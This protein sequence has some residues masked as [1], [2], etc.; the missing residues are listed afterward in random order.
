M[1]HTFG[2]Q[3]AQHGGHVN[4]PNYT[5]DNFLLRQSID[6]TLVDGAVVIFA[7]SNYPHCS[8]DLLTALVMSN[9][10]VH[11]ENQTSVARANGISKGGGKNANN[12]T[13]KRYDE[14]ICHAI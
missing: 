6:I 2:G 13:L 11:T 7:Q 3:H 12:R 5:N 9:S 8:R 14:R 1:R 4:D 10:S